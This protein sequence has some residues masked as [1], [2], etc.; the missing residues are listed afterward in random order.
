M[1]RPNFAVWVVSNRL[2][3]GQWKCQKW[4]WYYREGAILVV[5]PSGYSMALKNQVY[6]VMTRCRRCQPYWTYLFLKRLLLQQEGKS[7]TAKQGINSRWMLSVE[8]RWLWH[9]VMDCY[10]NYGPAS[11]KGTSSRLVQRSVQRPKKRCVQKK[12]KLRVA[13]IDWTEAVF[14]LGPNYWDH[15][16]PL[17]CSWP[18]R[19]SRGDSCERGSTLFSAFVRFSPFDVG[20]EAWLIKGVRILL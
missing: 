16:L 2:P 18:H 15:M 9:I 8:R 13:E 7:R 10:R 3:A 14:S 1:D 5:S 19:S 20:E 4:L 6:Q 17:A 12:E 11:A